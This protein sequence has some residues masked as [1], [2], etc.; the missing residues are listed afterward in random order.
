MT[1]SNIQHNTVHY[2]NLT[3]IDQDQEDPLENIQVSES[4]VFDEDDVSFTDFD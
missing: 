2:L 4:I 1:E 3:Q